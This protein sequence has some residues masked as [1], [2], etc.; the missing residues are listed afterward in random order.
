MICEK[1]RSAIIGYLEG[2]IQSLI[3]EHRP[4]IRDKIAREERTVYRSL[5]GTFKPFHEAIIPPEVLRISSFERTFSTKLGTTFE[6]CARLIALQTYASVE[7][8]YSAGGKMP[9]AAARKIEEIISRINEGQKPDFLAL[10]DEVLQTRDN[11]WVDR[12]VI[13]DL[14]LKDKDGLEYFFEIKSPKPNKGQCLE[15]TERLLR[16]HAIKQKPRPYVNAYL[17]MAYNPY[18]ARL[19]DYRHSFSL[20]YLD[21]EQE[22][23]AGADFWKLIGGDGT[24]EELL[25]IYRQVGKHKGKM[26]IDALAFGF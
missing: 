19:E 13:S 21:M 3:E 8:G 4:E 16:I 22:V 1:T 23:L 10:I 20:Q 11:Q 18:G 25:D 2:F 14:Y 6:E 15:V 24:Y 12:P 26:M 5:G 9:A 17:A 7:R